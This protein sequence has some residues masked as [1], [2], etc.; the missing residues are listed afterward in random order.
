[1]PIS[2]P[3]YFCS[4]GA[5]GILR[6]V[7]GY[8]ILTFDGGGIRG[9]YAARLLERLCTRV[10][11]LLE[12]VDLFAGTSTGG[13]IALS[14]AAGIS[15][16][17]VRDLYVERGRDV[18]DDSWWDDVR[19]LGKVTGAD[20]GSAKLKAWLER[21]FGQRTLG[22]LPKR[23]LIPTFDL[24]AP[25]ADGR[26]RTWKP[27]FFHNYPGTDTDANERIVD[28]ALRTTAAPTY[29]PSYQGFIDGG[30]VANNPSMA[31]LAQALDE[32]SGKQ[33]LED[34]RLLSL[35]TGLNPTFV[36]G[37]TLDWGFAQWAKPL[38]SL[39]IDGV[40]GVADYECKRLLGSRYCR[41]DPYLP[42]AIALDDVAKVE[43]LVSYADKVDLTSAA[44]FVETHFVSA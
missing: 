24:D 36:E 7:P 37:D 19:D 34:V 29:F 17:A 31:A 43:R 12:R 14:I 16:S 4:S 28:V 11:R 39:M 10:P 20:Y 32:R 44:R 23:V 8:R 42:E 41:V 1:M 38:V 15:P 26:P 13:L 27:K 3:W 2:V 25:A 33:K 30:V 18:F 40:M 9:A 6:G 22:S 5:R 21:T 35:S